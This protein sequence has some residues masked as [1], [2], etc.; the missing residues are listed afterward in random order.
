MAVTKTVDV[1]AAVIAKT[2]AVMT[3]KMVA[4]AGGVHLK[5]RQFV[6]AVEARPPLSLQSKC[7]NSNDHLSIPK[8]K[9]TRSKRVDRSSTAE[10]N[11]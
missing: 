6:Q 4:A 3:V 1:V 7:D 2:V 9:L 11:I 10:T 8:R 5:V